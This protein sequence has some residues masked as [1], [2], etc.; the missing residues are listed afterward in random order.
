MMDGTCEVCSDANESF[1]YPDET[2]YVLLAG[3]LDETA[4]SNT[5]PLT[6]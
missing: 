6:G 3:Q 5:V 1:S 2:V 4:M